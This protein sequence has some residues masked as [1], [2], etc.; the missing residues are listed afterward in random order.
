MSTSAPRKNSSIWSSA[1]RSPAWPTPCR[2]RRTLCRST[3]A[4][5][6]TL[7]RRPD[8]LRLTTWALLERPEPIPVEVEAYR[9]K[10]AAIADAQARGVVNGRIEPVDLMATLLGLVTA[11]S[12]AS[13]ALRSLAP[14]PASPGRLAAFRTVIVTAARTLTTP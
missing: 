1:A 7:Q 10:L 12:G 5:S 14:D 2:S 8:I 11:W 9:A 4:R 13:P 6:S 3:P